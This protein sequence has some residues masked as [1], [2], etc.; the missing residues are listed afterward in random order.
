MLI[1]SSYHY[2]YHC[3]CEQASSFRAYQTEKKTTTTWIWVLHSWIRLHWSSYLLL[4]F[5][6]TFLDFQWEMMHSRNVL[7]C[8]LVLTIIQWQIFCAKLLCIKRVPVNLTVL[9]TCVCFRGRFSWDCWGGW[10]VMFGDYAGSLSRSLSEQL[11]SVRGSGH[12]CGQRR[13]SVYV[14]WQWRWIS[15]ACPFTSRNTLGQ[16]DNPALNMISC[17]FLHYWTDWSIWEKNTQKPGRTHAMQC[18][19]WEIKYSVLN[20]LWHKPN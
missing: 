19:M 18:K 17:Y 16:I 8:S 2:S 11:A 13:W 4:L 1:Y 12:Q 5:K 6:K 7:L 20:L 9:I 14:C 3:C 10:T 15:E